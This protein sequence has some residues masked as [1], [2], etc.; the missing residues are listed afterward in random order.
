MCAKPIFIG[1]FS[2]SGKTTVGRILAER[3]GFPFVDT[4]E[5]VERRAGLRIP[6]IFS[7][8][9]ERTFRDLERE[10]V[11]ALSRVQNAVVSLGGGVLAFEDLV[12]EVR[13]RAQIVVLDVTP[14]EVLKRL[15][16]SRGDRPLLRDP[17]SLEDLWRRRKPLY[18]KIPLHVDT[19]GVGPYEVADRI[20][21][22]LSLKPGPSRRRIVL[23][24]ES[25]GVHYL[26]CEGLAGDRLR[27]LVSRYSSGLLLADWLVGALHGPSFESLG[28]AK[29]I[30]VGESAKE[31]GT[32]L[33]LLEHMA[34]VG[35]DRE[36]VLCALGGGV[37]G[38]LGGFAAS[39]WMRGIDWVNVP[40][41]LLAQV[42][43]GIGGKTA[44]N[45]KAGKNLVGSFHQPK[46][47]VADLRFL[48]TLPEEEFRQGLAEMA[49][50]ALLGERELEGILRERSSDLLDRDLEV[51]GDAVAIS[52][53]TKLS[54][55]EDDPEERRGLRVCLN[56]GHTLGHALEAASGYS[57]RHGDAVAIGLVFALQVSRSLGLCDRSFAIRGVSLLEGLGL[58]TS[59]AIPW[60]E[61]WPYMLR[62][63]KFTRSSCNMVLPTPGGP[64]LVKGIGRE[65]LREAYGWVFAGHAGDLAPS[66]RDGVGSEDLEEGAK[67][68]HLL[69]SPADALL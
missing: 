66:P 23:E 44:V 53:R 19:V 42:D 51:L 22:L 3:L 6:E 43:S 62:D 27:D 16:L 24:L 59:T 29:L 7:R 49:K 31:M 17:S 10:V 64:R 11:I 65:L 34:C 45:L 58:P 14:E 15:D 46:A 39:I 47:V 28:P 20:E 68:L 12:E 25:G 8:F 13:E 56:L 2:G 67:G 26:V 30:Q 35:L 32:L 69:Q 54:Y 61:V 40:T 21:R 60:D 52:L 36:G 41:T 33:E 63:K 5:L 37:V 1:G 4:D 48:L 18:D 50:Y 57:L 38:D 9:G 55:V